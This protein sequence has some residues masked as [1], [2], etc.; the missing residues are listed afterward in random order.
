MSLTAIIGASVIGAALLRLR[1]IKW[2]LAINAGKISNR[3]KYSWNWRDPAYSD[4][5]A[6]IQRS[7]G[8]KAAE[9]ILS[10]TKVCAIYR[11]ATVSVLLIIQCLG[12]LLIGK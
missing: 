11:V 9:G 6:F 3:G 5:Q 7:G 12:W 8:K 2:H 10:E 4:A 1:T